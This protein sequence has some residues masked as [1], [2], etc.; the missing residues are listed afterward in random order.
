MLIELAKD[1]VTDLNANAA[2]SVS[3][4]IARGLPATFKHSRLLNKQTLPACPAVTVIPMVVMVDDAHEDSCNIAYGNK[5]WVVYEDKLDQPGPLA[6]IGDHDELESM[7]TWTEALFK[8]LADLTTLAGQSRP[9]NIS[10]AHD[11]DTMFEWEWLLHHRVFVSVIE[12]E[13]RDN[14]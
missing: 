4:V 12:L 14:D 1:L 9:F 3:P 2:S 13:Y 10:F 6:D 8:Y 11:R 5:L 7:F